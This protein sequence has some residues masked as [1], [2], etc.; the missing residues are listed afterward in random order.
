MPSGD[1]VYNLHIQYLLLSMELLN[2]L[3]S[4]VTDL[5]ICMV[6][7]WHNQRL[8]WGVVGTAGESDG[9]VHTSIKGGEGE[10]YI[11]CKH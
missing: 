6:A 4:G 5:H 9:K 1:G 7:T 10:G 8:L 3:P 11:N 2:H